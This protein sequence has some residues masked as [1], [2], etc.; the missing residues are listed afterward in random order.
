MAG[1][2]GTGHDHDVPSSGCPLVRIRR[3]ENGYGRNQNGRGQMSQ[4]R[5]VSDE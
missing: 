5:I 3:A 4:P 1:T 2:R